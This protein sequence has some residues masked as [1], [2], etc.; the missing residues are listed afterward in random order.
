MF[1]EIKMAGK[2]HDHRL[3]PLS[4]DEIPRHLWTDPAIDAHF[5]YFQCD[6]CKRYFY[7]RK[8]DLK[9]HLDGTATRPLGERGS[10]FF[11]DKEEQWHMIFT[12]IS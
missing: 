10:M 2:D 6:R 1:K 11:Q 9:A 3:K 8:V 5:A 12:I 7:I 4:P